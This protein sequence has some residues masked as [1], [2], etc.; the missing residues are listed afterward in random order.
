MNDLDFSP[1]PVEP[2][3]AELEHRIVG[4]LGRATHRRSVP[5]LLVAAAVVA[6]LIGITVFGAT[7]LQSRKVEPSS[8]G[9]LGTL[10][11]RRLDPAEAEA[12]LAACLAR[13]P[14][15]DTTSAQPWTL[16]YARVQHVR[17]SELPDGRTST[18]L[19]AQN[20]ASVL[21]C[22]DGRYEAI[23]PGM[24]SMPSGVDPARATGFVSEEFLE[25]ACS[26]TPYA[27]DPAM[28]L[29]R[30]APAVRTVRIRLVVDGQPGTWM[31]AG[32]EGGFANVPVTDPQDFTRLQQADELAYEVQA[33]DGDGALAPIFGIHSPAGGDR[34]H[35]VQVAT[36]DDL[37][38]RGGRPRTTAAGLADCRR[39][40]AVSSGFPAD[41]STY[42]ALA[43]FAAPDRFLAVLGSGTTTPHL[44]SLFPARA[45]KVVSNGQTPDGQVPAVMEKDQL[46]FAM[47]DLGRAGL[48]LWAGGEADPSVT[49]IRYTFPNGDTAD[50][51]L[52]NGYWSLVYRSDR[53]F[54]D[55]RRPMT[56][57]P[58]VEIDITVAGGSPIHYTI[59]F[60][61]ET[62]C[63]RELP[64]PD[65]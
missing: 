35:T 38:G 64:L 10:D 62:A 56:E 63:A 11:V 31:T 14:H 32:A 34:T 5:R 37:A 26:G 19:V 1:P 4:Q 17:G 28:L 42:A 9:P 12:T 3:P 29:L 2:V 60:D 41:E 21:R 16:A 13:A 30:V 61:A 46:Y 54:L 58:P 51:A 8:P 40:V 6:V 20:Q 36:C 18:V 55:D 53:P 43:V 23:T 7:Q 44:C 47:T 33:L 15:D 27:G 49:A 24:P 59:P 48:T 45:L 25:P 39:M 52:A 22:L 57:L 50:A 65:C